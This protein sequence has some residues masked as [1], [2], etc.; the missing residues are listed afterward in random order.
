MHRPVR[1][2]IASALLQLA[3]SGLVSAQTSPPASSPTLA[4][5][6]ATLRK[7]DG[8]MPLYWDDAHGKLLLEISRFDQEFLYQISLASGVGSNPLGLDRG[9]LGTG[10]IVSF[11]RVGPKVLLVESNYK[12]RALG[13]PAAEQH[14]VADSFATSVLWGFTVEAFDAGRV[15]VDATSFFLRDAHGVA[16]RLRGAE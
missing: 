8:Y 2:V 15:L 14:A 12:F 1:I 7:I 4:E 11:E 10:A 5:R 9:Q 13:G 3:V 6:V 16:A